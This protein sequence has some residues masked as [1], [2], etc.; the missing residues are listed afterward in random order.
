MIRQFKL[1]T[2]DEIIC[3]VVNEDNIGPQGSFLLIRNCVLIDTVQHPGTRYHTLR[4]FMTNQDQYTQIMSIYIPHIVAQAVPE[5]S[6]ISHYMKYCET[7]VE[8]DE[9]IGKDLDSD[10]K[11]VVKFPGKTLH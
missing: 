6:L 3:D 1:S 11:N 5:D 2:G 8:Q 7:P 9:E 10:N 4:P